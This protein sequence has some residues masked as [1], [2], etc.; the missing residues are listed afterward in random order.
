MRVM[1][2]FTALLVAV[3]FAGETPVVIA[4]GGHDHTVMGTVSSVHENHLEVKDRQG[5]TVTVT[6]NE[7]T[8]ILQGNVKATKTD[9]KEGDR[10]V[11]TY[12][13]ND[14]NKILVGTLVRLAAKA[15]AKTK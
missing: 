10:I 13:S 1:I 4:H 8:R 9:I 12:R 5:K 14:K 2:R 3:L 15:A 7:K 6:L 11:V